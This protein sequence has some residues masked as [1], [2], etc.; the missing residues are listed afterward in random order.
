[1]GGFRSKSK[2]D[3][4]STCRIFKSWLYLALPLRRAPNMAVVRA[5]QM[6][7]LGAQE[8]RGSSAVQ[9]MIA[10]QLPVDRETEVQVK[11]R[12]SLRG[13]GPPGR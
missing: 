10:H 1:M 2:A 4:G 6:M 12:G 13:E 9:H 5:T 11:S 8:K 7:P 3:C